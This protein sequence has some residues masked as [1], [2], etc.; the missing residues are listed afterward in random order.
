MS[1]VL[2]CLLG[3]SVSAGKAYWICLAVHTSWR[4]LIFLA[5]VIRSVSNDEKKS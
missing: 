2:F 4:T 1:I 5:R 3:I